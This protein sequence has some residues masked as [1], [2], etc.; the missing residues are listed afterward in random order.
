MEISTCLVESNNLEKKIEKN[1]VMKRLSLHEPVA[2]LSFSF[3]ILHFRDL[4]KLG[5]LE[6][7]LV[8]YFLFSPWNFLFNT[9]NVKEDSSPTNFLFF[10]FLNNQRKQEN[11]ICFMKEKLE[12]LRESTPSASRWWCNTIISLHHITAVFFRTT[13]AVSKL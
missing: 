2:W 5:L 3:Y 1:V 10:Y 8:L 6:K 13:V 4:K 7:I 9:N 11:M 12:N